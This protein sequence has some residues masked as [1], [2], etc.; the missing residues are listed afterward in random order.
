MNFE[1]SEEHQAFS[2]SVARFAR[3][4]LADGALA[5]AHAHAYPWDTAALLAKQG[6]LGIA[7][8]EKDGGQGGTLMH[9]VLAIQQVA[10]VCPKSADIV[11]AGNF[12][13]IRTF[14]EY[15]SDEQKARFLPDLLGGRKLISLG[16]T[17]PD[18][19]S[20]VTDLKT[21]AQLEGDHYVINGS[22]IFS[23]HSPDAELFLIYVRF[24]PGV[25]GI[26]S[27]L[28][29][30]NTPGFEIGQPSSFMNGEK[31]SQLYFDNCRVPVTNLLLGEGG[32]KRQIAGFN[33][34]R[35]GN[36]SRALALGRHAFN[37]ARDYAQTRKQF[38]REL[39]EFQGLQWKFVDMAMK[40]EQAQLMLYRAALEGEHGLPSA[41]STAMAKLACNLAGWET[42][43]EA[44]QVMGG[45]GFSQESL[46]EYCVRRTR[47][48]MIA[49]GS[50][51]MLKNRIAEGIFDKT[52]S[53]RPSKA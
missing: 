3:E 37:V 35:L 34:E 14:V 30:R 40:L 12:G 51:E 25:G 53:Q 45:M 6:L 18:A 5:R 39:C 26:G 7:L 32:F 24:G 50:I 19:G 48:W 46:V 41:Q 38:G 2:D 44:M 36:A 28:V 9:A 29:E 11:Q 27:I 22:K 42:S 20:A 15:A 21:T 1:L 8:P 23:T 17:E 13:P 33:V 52:F 43:N 47:G 10:L 16:M 49:G 4:Q 31:W